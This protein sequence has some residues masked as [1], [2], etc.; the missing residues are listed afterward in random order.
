MGQTLGK[1]TGLGTKSQRRLPIS[2]SGKL[3]LLKLRKATQ[4]EFGPGLWDSCDKAV[5]SMCPAQGLPTRCQ[6]PSNQDNFL[7]QSGINP[8]PLGQAPAPVRVQGQTSSH[9][10]WKEQ[11]SLAASCPYTRISCGNQGQVQAVLV[12][13]VFCIGVMNT[14]PVKVIHPSSR[15]MP[16][17]PSVWFSLT[18]PNVQQ[19][20]LLSDASR[21]VT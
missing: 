12:S 6:F 3:G 20:C 2:R 7:M 19:L 5:S 4:V 14:P 21:G 13:A 1:G 17:L 11:T 10:G 9:C 16:K 15:D 18:S 8:M